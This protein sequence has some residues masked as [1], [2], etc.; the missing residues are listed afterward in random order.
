MRISD[1]SSDVCSSDLP[2]ALPDENRHGSVHVR[3]AECEGLCGRSQAQHRSS[4][5]DTTAKSLQHDE[6]TL[7]QPPGTQTMVQGEGN[8][9]CGGVC[10]VVDGD[11]HPAQIDAHLAGGC[12]EN[13]SIRL[14]RNYTIYNRCSMYFRG[15]QL[16]KARR[17]IRSRAQ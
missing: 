5:G 10:M 11:D 13:P 8:G 14:M 1:W 6:I 15:Q 4:P 17:Q 16:L 3:A 9:C 2:T 12:F 7:L